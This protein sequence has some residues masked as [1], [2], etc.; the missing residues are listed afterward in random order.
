MHYDVFVFQIR[1]GNFTKTLLPKQAAPSLLLILVLIPIIIVVIVGAVWYSYIK[2]RKMA[3]QMDKQLELLECDIRNDIRQG[4]V[5]MQTEKCDLIENVGAIPFLDYK[6]FASRIFFPDG[7]PVMTSCIKDIGQ[8]AVKGQPDESCQAL[9]RL[10][11]DQVFLTSF[12]H[13]LEEQKNFNVKEK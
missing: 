1:V 2:Q 6:H 11:R 10:I 5:D 8:D 4:F 13:A 7:G 3:A 9:S 12:V